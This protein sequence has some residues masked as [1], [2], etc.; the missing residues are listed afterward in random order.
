[1]STRAATG[2]IDRRR[3]VTAAR[4]R[5]RRTMLLALV[6][7]AASVVGTW[8]I[9]SGPLLSVS[10][11]Q[12][13]GY[14]QPDQATVARTIQ[15]AARHGTMLRLPTVAVREALSPYPWVADV[16][17]HHNWPRGVDVQIVQ[18]TP[19]AIAITADGRRLVVSDGGRILGEQSD[20]EANLPRFMVRAGRIGA[21]LTSP[22]QRAPFEFLAAMSPGVAGRVQDLRVEGGVV[23]G[24]L[25]D[26]P[27]LRLGPPRAMWAKGR[28][29][30][31]VVSAPRLAE[32]LASAEYLDVSAPKQP[33]LAGFTTPDTPD[34]EPSTQG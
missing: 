33:T 28:A 23:V 25:E 3:A 11:V 14:R 29:V 16:S 21:W 9:A 10:N 6:A 27:E 30:E 24:R 5:R 19:A 15:I 31:A 7:T 34:D 20:A 2:L 4:H 8:W 32:P 18:A 1:M 12:I 22:E 17:V 13:S 26:G